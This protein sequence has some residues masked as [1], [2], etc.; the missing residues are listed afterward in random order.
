MYWNEEGDAHNV[1]FLP[2]VT[3]LKYIV[4]AP[5]VW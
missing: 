2:E 1:V 5:N 3:R 4:W